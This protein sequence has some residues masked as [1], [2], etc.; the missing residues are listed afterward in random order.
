MHNLQ[1]ISHTGWVSERFDTLHR[2]GHL[3]DLRDDDQGN[4]QRFL[5]LHGDEVL[6]CHAWKTWLRWDGSRWKDDP[7][8]VERLAMDVQTLILLEAASESEPRRK[9]LT[10]WAG[11]SGSAKAIRELLFCARSQV[12]IT[13]EELDADP[14][15]LNFQNGTLNLVTGE[16]RD[17]WYSDYI[18]K[19]VPH[20]YEPGAKAPRFDQFKLEIM[21]GSSDMVSF[22][23]RAFGSALLGRVRD[24]KL[25]IGVGPGGNGKGT[26]CRALQ[27]ALGP[28]YS[29]EAA[30]GLLL[31]KR[32]VDHPTGLADLRGMRLVTCQ[33]V[34]RGKRL[35]EEVV[36]RLTGGDVIKA[37]WMKKDFFQ[38]E[39]SH[40]L[41]VFTNHL[42]EIQETGRALWR[43]VLLVPF[44]YTVPD[45]KMD[46]DL[47]VTLKAE[48]TGIL[49]WLVKGCQDYVLQGLCPPR[50]VTDATSAYERDVDSVGGFLVERC[51]V[52]KGEAVRT[53][54]GVLYSAYEQWCQDTGYVPLSLTH[55]KA[56]L[57][58][59]GFKQKENNRGRYWEAIA[60]E[61]GG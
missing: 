12:P 33:E 4:A 25:F 32:H 28:D 10:R 36:K 34:G 23:Q 51:R 6:Y 48:A 56:E 5:H 38:F 45:E 22:L 53:K 26:L 40:S 29:M 30:P 27:F 3:Q 61:G 16:F 57:I 59:R 14:N 35:D 19:Q 1:V 24:H 49:A 31:Q 2:Q 17:A 37:R 11:R 9:E 58:Q 18:T 39:P 8:A 60:V 20:F 7:L 42:P 13:P 43:R 15:L 52:L 55:F 47:D 54:A 21:D 41:W 50:S 46:L 44:P